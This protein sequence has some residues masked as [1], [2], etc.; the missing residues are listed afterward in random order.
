MDL[1][2]LAAAVL[3]ANLLVFLAGCVL[4]GYRLHSEHGRQMPPPR[5]AASRAVPFRLVSRRAA[6]THR[7]GK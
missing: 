3:A 1:S 6:A 5:T 2:Y 7:A 4:A